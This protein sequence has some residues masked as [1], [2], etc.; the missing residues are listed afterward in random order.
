V[1]LISDTIP[2]LTG[3]VSQ[4]ADNLRYSNTA[5]ACENAMLSP[6]TGMQKRQAA[7][8]LGEMHPYG[9]TSDLALD[10]KA[11]VH[12]IDRDATEHYALTVDSNG[13]RAFDADT[14]QALRVEV[15]DS[16]STD[17]L[18]SGTTNYAESLRFATVA[19]TTFVV[20]RNVTV[21]GGE[22]RNFEA[23]HF[24]T[25]PQLAYDTDRGG[26]GGDDGSTTPNYTAQRSTLGGPVFRIQ[27]SNSVLN[28]SSGQS[29]GFQV[30]NRSIAVGSVSSNTTSLSSFFTS[31]SY[32]FTDRANA[33][34]T[35]PDTGAAASINQ[36][37]YFIIPT[38]GSYQ[39]AP[40]MLAQ[41]IYR[42]IYFS[43]SYSLSP[44]DL[45]TGPFYST[46]Y[47]DHQQNSYIDYTIKSR[48]V[49]AYGPSSSRPTVNGRTLTYDLNINSNTGKLEISDDNGATYRP[50]RVND[51]PTFHSYAGDAIRPHANPDI[52]FGNITSASAISMNTI[53]GSAF[54]NTGIAS[55]S[56]LT[57]AEETL[58][59]DIIFV[60]A[61]EHTANDWL[62]PNVFPDVQ[63]WSSATL[64]H[65]VVKTGN[66]FPS[67]GTF[68]DLA[69]LS[70][71]GPGSGTAAPG[72]VTLV[73]GDIGDSG[74]YVLADYNQ[75]K[76]V[77]TYQTPYILDEGTLPHKI[78]R[79]FEEDGTPYFTLTR[80]QYAPRICGDSDSNSIPSFV[81]STIN[82]V[83]VHGGRLGFLAGENI[84]LSGT[85]YGQTTNFF[86]STAVQ[87]L[88]DDRIDLNASTGD[89]AKL[90]YA[91][92]FANTLLLFSERA[93]YR[94]VSSGALTPATSLI[95]QTGAHATSLLARPQ[96]VGKSVFAAVNDVERTTVREF[97]A[98]I[99]TDILESNE[100]TTQVPK[101]I[102][103][104]VHKL[105]YSA[106]KN[107]LVA[108]S[109]TNTNCLYVYNYYDATNQRLQSAWSKW[110]L[111]DDTR[112]VNVE[113]LEDYLHL[114]CAVRV[115]DYVKTLELD[116]STGTNFG[117]YQERTH[118]VRIPLNEIT[119][120]NPKSFPVLA[121]FRV[122]RAQCINVEGDRQDS[123][124]G[125]SQSNQNAFSFS[126][127]ALSSSNLLAIPL[128]DGLDFSIVEL[129]YKTT[130]TDMR[131][132]F[133]DAAA[134]GVSTPLVAALNIEIDSGSSQAALAAAT[135]T[136]LASPTQAN[137]DAINAIVVNTDNTKVIVIGRLDGVFLTP[138]DRVL[139]NITTA[140]TPD[141]VMGRAYTL[142]YEQ[143]PIF[144]KSGESNVGKTDARLQLRYCTVT[145]DET[146][147]F[148]VEVT[149][150]G[151]QA[152]KYDYEAFKPGV[153][154]FSLGT[155][156]FASESFRFPVFAQNQKCKIV[157]KNSTVLPSTLTSL[158]WQ[159]F[160]SPKAVSVR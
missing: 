18:T 37:T 66:N 87:L 97:R 151:R 59:N 64:T 123:A 147:S 139:N 71:S 130:A 149:A 82:D 112:I 75:E 56:G 60:V 3:G 95:Q 70:T 49:G 11:A 30:D 141:F 44:N 10:D 89:V 4:Q 117:A 159:G 36:Y 105:A 146:S 46:A 142:T 2:N 118:M 33:D 68:Q 119:E 106:K 23:H 104:D 25:Y 140:V 63:P 100:V 115:P 129:P 125:V 15:D 73:G 156:R 157:F 116:N 69:A 114:I 135:G 133:T 54:S 7:E 20:N 121:D 128:P 9:T 24:A 77:E 158:E 45:L 136:F 144:Y 65:T 55:G 153:A 38:V 50:L 53:V 16:A 107:I 78:Q 145:C 90:I 19:D 61:G 12:W 88:D 127:S 48:T 160:V 14:G 152:R 17:Y 51:H 28:Q 27:I 67:V 83:F 113:V 110:L 35:R 111:E 8:W 120:V 126:T 76:Y 137:A 62:G 29:W 41:M 131:T 26:S 86:R 79:L 150:D 58:L 57:T 40:Q 91:A 1:P 93:Q 21:A 92:P 124:D 81:G 34:A 148:D 101:F 108:L 103:S 84:I 122:T 52:D 138:E 132:I 22:N 47:V 5:E 43:A 6:V 102:P 32:Q 74:Y 85:D 72:A 94:L 154:D 80:H 134:Y 98:D 109:H 42:S 96:R 13:L 31:L 155:R 143:S 39:G 99:D